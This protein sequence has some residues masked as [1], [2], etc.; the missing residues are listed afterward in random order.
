MKLSSKIII[1]FV[2]AAGSVYPDT[3]S[4]SVK[5]LQKE[6]DSLNDKADNFLLTNIDS[7]YF[8]ATKAFQKAKKINYSR[9]ILNA[10][11]YLQCRFSETEK[12]D[13]TK[14][15]F[16][17]EKEICKS[18]KFEKDLTDAYNIMAIAYQE[19]SDFKNALIYYNKSYQVAKQYGDTTALLDYYINVA[20]LHS[21]THNYQ[22]EIQNLLKGLGFAKKSGDSLSIAYMYN[23]IGED[24]QEIGNFKKAQKYFLKAKKY[25]NEKEDVYISS[26]ILVNSAENYFELGKN[27][28]ALSGINKAILLV[29]NRLD[30]NFS[31]GALLVKA[32]ILGAMGEYKAEEK[33]L[34]KLSAMVSDEIDKDYIAELDYFYSKIYYI[35]KN[36][37]EARKWLRKALSFPLND[38]TLP[39][40]VKA[41]KLF[42]KTYKETGDYK[43]ALAYFKKYKFLSD[44]LNN[45]KAQKIKIDF[46]NMQKL[47]FAEEELNAAEKD[48]KIIQLELKRKRTTQLFF[49]VILWGLIIF[50]IIIF[51][52]YKKVKKQNREL[53][54]LNRTKEQMLK[55]FPHDLRNSL[56]ATMSYSNIIVEEFDELD[57][58]ELLSFVKKVYSTANI[59]LSLMTNLLNWVL[60]STGELKINPVKMELC[61]FINDLNLK[62]QAF[63]S[64]KN[65]VSKVECEKGLSVLA[66]ENSLSLI[67]RNLIFNAVKF[68]PENSDIKVTANAEGNVAK[69]SVSDSGVGMS[70]ELVEKILNTNSNESSSGTAGESGTGLGLNLVKSFIS[71]NNGKLFITSKEGKGSTFTFTLPLAQ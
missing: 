67:L 1:F 6:I 37:V 54:K 57:R 52:Y 55:I 36:F 25:M 15:Y 53:D 13:S 51:R 45:I 18:K 68:S 69:I 2:F 49:W 71:K 66:D 38:D 5:D 17:I 32:E 16:N 60:V 33:I 23:N 31:F 65:I 7:L 26:Y 44:S 11:Y 28:S 30:I 34:N 40:L 39:W 24:Y 19:K 14:K 21:D 62:I 64:N 42:E 29:G 22:K 3:I 9:G 63:L 61:E 58:D 10:A 56:A 41:A 50:Y 35:R 59:S 20:T 8:Y 46:E 43:T 47:H 27:D 48:K 4:D 12:I 70:P